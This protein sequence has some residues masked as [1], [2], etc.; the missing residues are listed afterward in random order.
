MVNGLFRTTVALGSVAA[1]L[2]LANP[3]SAQVVDRVFH[4]PVPY[5]TNYYSDGNY[6]PLP[7]PANIIPGAIGYP[8]QRHYE[9]GYPGIW[10][11]ENQLPLPPARL[12]K[13]IPLGPGDIIYAATPAIVE[14]QVPDAS[15]LVS[16]DG[17]NTKQDGATRR[18]TSPPLP[19]GH[20]YAYEIKAV[21]K[22]NG[23][24][25]VRSRVVEVHA[26]DRV[27]VVFHNPKPAAAQ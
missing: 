26:G 8:Y 1:L 14:I 22:D 18:F 4:T 11:E 25:V 9:G 2:T 10:S 12:M 3:A 20:T 21:W 5:Y 24:E 16:F 27:Q 23:V 13:K 15:A 19:L 7:L 17:A 6:G